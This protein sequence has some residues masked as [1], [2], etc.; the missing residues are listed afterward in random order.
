MEHWGC[1]QDQQR[2]LLG[3]IGR[4]TYFKYKKLPEVRLPRDTMERIS[5]LMGIHKG[6][7]IIF[8]NHP[9]RAYEWVGR[10]NAAAPF[11][12]MTALSYMLG[13]KVID[14]ADVRQ[15]LAEANAE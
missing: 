15:Y 2:V 9:E 4:T 11:N 13:G 6:L 7:R 3:E 12:G 1:D 5:Y 10:A 8:S 14:L